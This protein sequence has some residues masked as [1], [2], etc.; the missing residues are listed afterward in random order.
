MNKK[1]LSAIL[2]GALMVTA[3]GTFVSCKDY[4]D[5]IDRID[6]SLNDLK[7]QIDALQTKVNEGKWITN[8]TSVTGG[9]TVTFSDGSSYTITN[10]EKGD[11]GAAGQDGKSVE[12][13]DGYWYIDGEKTEY[14]AV[15]KGDLGKVNV[16]YVNAEDGYWYF[17]N[18]KGEAV[19][20]T[21]KAI[22]ATYVVNADG[23]YTLY[24]PNAD[25]EMQSIKLPTAG[26]TLSDVELLGQI[27]LS[28]LDQ[29]VSQTTISSDLTVSYKWIEKIVKVYDGNKETS[30]SAQKTVAKGQV[31]TTL[32]PKNTNLMARIVAGADAADMSFTLKNSKGAQLPISL[33][34]AAQYTGLLSRSASGLYAIALDNTAD[35][36]ATAAKYTE[37]FSTG[38]YALVEKSG[39]TSNYELGVTAT[40]ATVSEGKVDKVDGN[41]I[42][43]AVY[44]VN[45]NKA[46]TIS[47]TNP[48]FVYDYYVEAVD[49]TIANMFGFAADK[50]NGTFTVTK[51]AD[52][53]TTA[54]FDVYVYKLHI[55]G[56]IYREQISIK[57]VRTLGAEVV[58]NLG[59]QTIKATGSMKMNVNLADMFTALGADADI[60]KNSELG[61]K[62][63]TAAIKKDADDSAQSFNVVYT[64]KKA[65]GSVT[66]SINE[67]TQFDLA[68]TTV[69]GN[70][71]TL[72]PGAAYTITITYKDKDAKDLNSIKVKFTP[73]M[74]KLSSYITKRTAV[75]NSNILMAY[76]V[77]PAANETP[78]LDS[79]YD[80]TTGFTKLGSTK[81]EDKTV[82][83]FAL[84]AEQKI[85][86]K[87]VVGDG[88]AD[89]SSNDI[90]LHSTSI[91]G[92]A[93]FWAYAQ[94][95]N[96]NLTAT[97][98]D[99][100]Y[101]FAEDEIKAAAFTVKV[102][103]ALEAGKIVPASGASIT[104]PAA[105]AG[106]IAKLTPE[107]IT[108]Y[109]YNNQ[110]YSLFKTATST[111][112]A[113]KYTYINTVEFESTDNVIYTVEGVQDA[114]WDKTA[115]KEVAGYVKIKSGNIS[116]TTQTSI[117]VKVTDM[118]GYVK[119]AEIPLTITVGE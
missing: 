105:A 79:T 86:G 99:G 45:L 91:N 11:T 65:N 101:E 103:S 23:I 60:W 93:K 96:V 42:T 25:G 58:Y 27:S 57:P 113:Y 115:N 4:D 30:W 41:S 77:D 31:L 89:I 92:T 67:A 112:I 74:P 26:S 98:L 47:F 88:M 16:P 73:V 87:K 2:F 6:N 100:A 109:T 64:Y 83:T 44:E 48:E 90:T 66:T 38:L 81:A 29:N 24:V 13:K 116:Q 62:S 84:D 56:K 70:A 71:A 40:E 78:T 117:K 46:N 5:D 95:L 72:E 9:F 82:I 55:D 28:K 104:L 36:Y 102:Q 43:G 32:A 75:W 10:G 61:V 108:G 63:Y 51:L 8:L 18:E 114:T 107:M 106:E 34:A 1:F 22:G 59:E 94:E 19:K 21:Y 33:S 52:K 110:P 12:V 20:S 7:S 53:I 37:K 119:T 76:F 80:L 14:V 35:T 15:T 39:F 50:A 68:P 118:Y 85:N 17:Y 97:Y 3:T 69:S 54:S 49:P 111:A